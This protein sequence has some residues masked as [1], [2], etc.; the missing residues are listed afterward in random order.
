MAHV[1]EPGTDRSV[2][3]VIVRLRALA[4]GRDGVAHFAR[5]YADVTEG[6]DARLH[7]VAFANP[8]FVARLDVVFADLFF[9]A[10][11]AH[12]RDPATAPRA[13]A[14]LFEARTRRRIEPVRFAVAGMN[15]HINRDLPIAVVS[16][17][18]ELGVEPEGERADFE[19]VNPILAEVEPHAKALLLTGWLAVLARLVHRFHHL[20]DAVAIWDVTR[21]REAAFANA[22]A[23]WALRGEDEVAAALLL[24]LDRSVGLAGRAL[25]RA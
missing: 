23:L 22:Q 5:L 9:D 18:T 25:L 7:G 13:W 4:D 3:D 21:A 6:V 12:E 8:A 24:A 17:C 2:H 19:R 14:P 11:A 15:A 20:D 16:T 10:L 1:A